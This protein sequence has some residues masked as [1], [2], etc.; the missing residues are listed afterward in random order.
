LGIKIRISIS[1]SGPLFQA[2]DID[3]DPLCWFSQTL[4]ARFEIYRKMPF[5]NG[6]FSP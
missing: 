3:A 5:F 6:I 2:A 4:G 1:Q